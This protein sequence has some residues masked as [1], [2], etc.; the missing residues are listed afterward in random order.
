MKHISIKQ[1]AIAAAAGAGVFFVGQ[2]FWNRRA[3]LERGG[4]AGYADKNLA[5]QLWD[6]APDWMR[7]LTVGAL[8]GA[9]AAF[10]VKNLGGAK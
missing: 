9:T 5:A 7:T 8:S 4:P 10:A 3:L 6:A 1:T 2:A